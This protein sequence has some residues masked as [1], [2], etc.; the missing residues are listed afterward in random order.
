MWCVLTRKQVAVITEPVTAFVAGN[1]KNGNYDM[2]TG[3][4]QIIPGMPFIRQNRRHQMVPFP[5][6]IHDEINID[7]A[8]T[9]Y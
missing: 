3:D 2:I 9:N 4:L 7:V 6:H 8:I 1:G 5:T